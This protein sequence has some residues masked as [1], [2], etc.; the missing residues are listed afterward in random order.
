M[1]ELYNYIF[2]IMSRPKKRYNLVFNK[3]KDVVYGG[4][5][6]EHLEGK[7]Y[8]LFFKNCDLRF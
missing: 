4:K 3:I 1:C 7:K 2:D 6:I 5:L 8:I